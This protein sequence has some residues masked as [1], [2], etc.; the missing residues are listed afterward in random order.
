MRH[1]RPWVV[2]AGSL[3]AGLAVVTA[4]AWHQGSFLR[5]SA[6]NYLRERLG[7]EFGAQFQ[8][9]DLRGTW[10]PPGLSLGRVTINRPG[11]SRVLTAEDVRISFN[12]YA[13]LFGRER[14]G[15]VVIVRPRLFVRPATERGTASRR[16]RLRQW[17][18]LRQ[19][20]HR[21]RRRCRCA[22]DPDR[23][24]RAAALIP[25][26]AVPPAGLRGCRRQGRD[27]GPRRRK[28]QRDRDQPVGP[29]FQRERARR[30]GG[31]ESR[32][33]T[34]RATGRPGPGGCRR[35][36]RGGPGHGARARCRGRGAHGDAPGDGGRRR[37]S[38]RSRASCR[39]ASRKLRRW[40][41]GRMQPAALRDLRAR[42]RGTGATRR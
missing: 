37:A 10:F 13:V 6:A 2:I 31:R 12:P 15:R 32:D 30:F 34:R 27:V 9:T 11:E 40:P 8:T 29:R 5:E 17:K 20:R 28:R 25:A 39:R 22:A 16:R 42:S 14:L 26:A 19:R 1:I 7:T 33:R 36:D 23:G 3:L 35:H 18:R 21:L 24:G 4:V 41:A 38:S